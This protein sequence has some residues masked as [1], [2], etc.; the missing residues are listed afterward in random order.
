P[1]L[2]EAIKRLC[3]AATIGLV[4][5][6]LDLRLYPFI[7]QPTRPVEKRLI[8]IGSMHW[9]PTRRA[10]LRLLTK[11]WPAIKELEPAAELE[12]VGWGATEVL[13]GFTAL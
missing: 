10:A 5:L 7:P 12:I 3:P 9:W 2:V 1:D 11:L 6:P 4:P 13:A 8:L